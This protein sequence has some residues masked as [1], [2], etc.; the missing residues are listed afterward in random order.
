[1][2]YLNASNLADH[3]HTLLANLL[4]EINDMADIIVHLNNVSL[5]EKELMHEVTIMAKFSPRTKPKKNQRIPLDKMVE[6]KK[7]KVASMR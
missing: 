5:A 4:H 3:L 1:M 6:Q 7:K 2:S